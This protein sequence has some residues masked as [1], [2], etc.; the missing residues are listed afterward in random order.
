MSERRGGSPSPSPVKR[1]SAACAS[2]LVQLNG[3]TRTF[4]PL[5]LVFVIYLTWCVPALPARTE[6]TA[7]PKSRAT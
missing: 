3:R 6:E 4:S 5:G 1:A 2:R 7:Q